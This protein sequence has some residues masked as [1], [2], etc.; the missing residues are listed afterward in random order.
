MISEGLLEGATLVLA[1]LF[2]D[3]VLADLEDPAIGRGEGEGEV[4]R[5]LEEDGLPPR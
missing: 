4:L 2:D 3:G 5:L 1:A